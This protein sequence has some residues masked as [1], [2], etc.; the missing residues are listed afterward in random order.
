MSPGDISLARRNGAY[1]S[2]D[3]LPRA[4]VNCHVPSLDCQ[5]SLPLARCCLARSVAT[6]RSCRQQDHSPLP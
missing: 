3:L 4:E 5:L 2:Q 6:C 1:S